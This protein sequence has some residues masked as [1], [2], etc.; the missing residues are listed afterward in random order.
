MERQSMTNSEKNR[1]STHRDDIK[2]RAKT[3]RR[4][5]GE[6]RRQANSPVVI[7]RR[8]ASDR[9]EFERRSRRDGHSDPWPA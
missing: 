6:D 5:K 2:L 8:A 3:E 9:R 1:A 7:E 4:A